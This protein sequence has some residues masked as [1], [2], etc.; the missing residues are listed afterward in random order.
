MCGLILLDKPEDI[1]SFTAVNRV[2]RALNC[3]K[4]GH[5]GT[6]DPLATGV[7]PILL[8][9]ATRFAQF[10]PSHRKAYLAGFKLGTTT[11]TLD[12]T[13]EVL[14]QQ[15]VSVSHEQIAAALAPFRGNIMQVPPMVS[16]LKRDGKRLYE[17]ARQGIEIEREPRP[18]EIF[19]L[20]LVGDALYV[21]C[22]AGTY[23]RSLIDDLGRALGCGAC[24]TTLRRVAANGFDIAQCTPLEDIADAPILAI[25][26]A[27]ASYPKVQVSAAQAVRFANGGHL[28]CSFVAS[29]CPIKEN[30]D[31]IEGELY[32]V[33]HEDIFL[34]LGRVQGEELA[35][36][37]LLVNHPALARAPLHGGE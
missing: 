1:T 7:L 35:I 21:E 30:F 20:E 27:L 19:A 16:A 5:T 4:A 17:L 24:M 37:R 18:V 29:L 34:G 15:P 9:G 13:G 26:D 8:G 11:T 32:R 12:I 28:R 31:P 25:E 10:L 3:K 14:T 6:L 22:S 23:V 33:F 36:A 2:R